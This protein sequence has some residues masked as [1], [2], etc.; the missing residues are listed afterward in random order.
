MD[1]QYCPQCGEQVRE[2]DSFCFECGTPLEPS[3]DGGSQTGKL[4]TLWAAVVV[5]VLAIL[6]NATAV[7]FPETLAEQSA[8]LLGGETTLSQEVIVATGL[9]GIGICLAVLVL[10][11]H[12]YQEESLDRR[13]F[14]GLIGGGVVG[15]FL[16][17]AIL[18]LV[19][20]AI[21]AYGLLVALD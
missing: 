4:G 11:Y 16:G 13:F 20:V 10:C 17:S 19:L 5:S 15:F 14:W 3:D 8:E 9:I 6:E 7:L 21:G 18:F 2:D 12:Y 1:I